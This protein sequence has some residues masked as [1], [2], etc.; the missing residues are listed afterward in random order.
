MYVLRHFRKSLPK[1]F[2]A[3]F[4]QFAS[5]N[6]NKRFFSWWEPTGQVCVWFLHYIFFFLKLHVLRIG[7]VNYSLQNVFGFCLSTQTKCRCWQVPSWNCSSPG[8]LWLVPAEVHR[9]LLN[10]NRS[11]GTGFRGRL[12]WRCKSCPIDL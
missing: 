10:S 3:S 6:E 12:E 7:P 4:F 1:I 9:W 8:W 2:Q 11:D 5:E